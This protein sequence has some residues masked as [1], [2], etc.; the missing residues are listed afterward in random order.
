MDELITWVPEAQFKLYIGTWPTK[1]D[2]CGVE[3]IAAMIR[4]VGHIRI[5]KD[6]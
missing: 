6:C 4:R 2:E 1:V 5:Y 3:Y